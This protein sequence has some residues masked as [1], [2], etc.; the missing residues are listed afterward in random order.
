MS[1]KVP[2]R[3]GVDGYV[4]L[5]VA[6]DAESAFDL[7]PAGWPLVPLP[8]HECESLPPSLPPASTHDSGDPG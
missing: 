5:V 1:E 3:C 4:R 7:G 2:E 6:G 8:E